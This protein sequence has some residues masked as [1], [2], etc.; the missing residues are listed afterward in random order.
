[1]F[2][3]HKSI[4]KRIFSAQSVPVISTLGKRLIFGN[5][6]IEII[7]AVRE[8]AKSGNTGSEI[9]LTSKI[10]EVLNETNR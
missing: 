7:K 5:D 3:T 2:R 10:P 8:V 1:M 6:S 4:G 9:T